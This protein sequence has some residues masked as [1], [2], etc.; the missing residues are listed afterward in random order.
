MPKLAGAPTPVVVDGV[1]PS[2]TSDV[3]APAGI[4]TAAVSTYLLNAM[5]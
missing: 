5:T 1:P 2:I 3:N 4:V